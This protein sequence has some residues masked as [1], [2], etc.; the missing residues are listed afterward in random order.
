MSN[1]EINLSPH[2]VL[3]EVLEQTYD[4]VGEVADGWFDKLKD[5]DKRLLG[6]MLT[7]TFWRWTEET[8]NQPEFFAI[9]NVET[10]R[11]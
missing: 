2:S 4:Q 11:L 8:N 6:K 10:I 9:K 3:D 7:D 5:E 1:P